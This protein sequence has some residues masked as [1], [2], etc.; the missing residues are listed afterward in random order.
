M[1]VVNIGTFFFLRVNPICIFVLKNIID[2]SIIFIYV[3]IL[4]LSPRITRVRYVPSKLPVPENSNFSI[5]RPR[6]GFSIAEYSSRKGSSVG[7]VPWLRNQV[8]ECVPL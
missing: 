4:F 5:A 8:Y 2:M 6:I 3:S 1:L 7:K